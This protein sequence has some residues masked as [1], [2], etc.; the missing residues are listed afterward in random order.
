MAPLL[1]R[2]AMG[3]TGFRVLSTLEAVAPGKA[4]VMPLGGDEAEELDCDLVVLQTGRAAVAG[5]A[6]AL[7]DGGMAEVH[8]IGDCTAPRRMSHALFEAQRL[9]R[10]I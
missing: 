5:P 4:M 3:K 1:G 8:S 6:Q 7:R 2:L 9:A 10:V